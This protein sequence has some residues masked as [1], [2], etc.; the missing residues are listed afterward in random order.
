MGTRKFFDGRVVINSLELTDQPAS[1]KETR[2]RIASPKGELT[3]LMDEGQLTRYMAYV[4]FREGIVRGDHYHK[5]RREYFYLIAGHASLRLEEVS[6][7]RK[8][9][10]ALNPGDLA[11]IEP[12]IAHTFLPLSPGHAIEFAVEAF[13]AA[14]VYRHIIVME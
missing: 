14:D 6:T 3:V 7:G 13:D 5:V 11:F 2:A 10:V 4:E 8:E 12:G 9:S 1:R